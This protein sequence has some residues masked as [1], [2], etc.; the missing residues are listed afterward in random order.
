MSKI[1]CPSAFLLLRYRNCPLIT[2]LQ[3]I[4]NFIIITAEAVPISREGYKPIYHCS[5]TT[6]RLGGGENSL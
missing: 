2:Q 5:A 6:L 3:Y 1:K 4:A